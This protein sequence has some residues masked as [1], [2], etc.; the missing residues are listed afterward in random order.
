[1]N[2]YTTEL[3]EARVERTID[4]KLWA[5]VSSGCSKTY[6]SDL[7]N[8]ARVPSGTMDQLLARYVAGL[9]I[10]KQTCP[11]TIADLQNSPAF[12]PWAQKL[13]QMGVTI[14]QVHQLYNQ[15]CG[16]LPMAGNG[17]TGA[18]Q[19]PQPVAPQRPATVAI[20]DE[21]D[22]QLGDI[23]LDSQGRKIPVQRRERYI[24]NIPDSFD[25]EEDDEE[26][27]ANVPE[28][29]EEPV[30]DD[31][32][33]AEVEV[34]D[35]NTGERI[36]ADEIEDTHEDDEPE[37]D[38]IAY[39]D[40][41]DD[42]DEEVQNDV[43]DFNADD[44]DIVPDE[45]EDTIDYSTDIEDDVADEHED[46][47]DFNEETDA[48]PEPEIED[49]VID[50]PVDA[51]DAEIEDEVIDEPVANDRPG[52]IDYPTNAA[53]VM[54]AV[55]QCL[56]R[57]NKRVF[58]NLHGCSDA[59]ECMIPVADLTRGTGINDCE[60]RDDAIT[61][62]QKPGAQCYKMKVF[63]GDPEEVKGDVLWNEAP[64]DTEYYVITND[65]GA[66]IYYKEANGD[67]SLTWVGDLAEFGFRI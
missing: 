32:P 61:E 62:M 16:K 12:K 60:N 15:N 3:F 13:V 43:T 38:E 66:R 50:E 31:E 11:E 25:V 27:E 18:V 42:E 6:K 41:F 46:E 44:E 28:P 35:R 40:S 14:D 20:D 8:S 63:N 67:F 49:D 24:P 21:D 54:P 30:T 39:G 22:F 1:M 33:D 53:D 34:Y 56:I 48:D 37:D 58:S 19:T 59:D 65:E 51:T 47:I 29:V 10:L 36:E 52:V 7:G 64:V 17:T 57:D 55:H 2:N 45:E 5:S 26:E 23:N 9:I 4:P